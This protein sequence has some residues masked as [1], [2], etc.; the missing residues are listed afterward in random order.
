[1]ATHFH[2][3]MATGRG[4][5]GPHRQGL[6]QSNGV[7]RS[8]RAPNQKHGRGRNQ[9]HP[10]GRKKESWMVPASPPT[11]SIPGDDLEAPS[12]ST[13][14]GAAAGHP[15]GAIWCLQQETGFSPQSTSLAPSLQGSLVLRSF[16]GQRPPGQPPPPRLQGCL[17]WGMAATT[18]ASERARVG[19]VWAAGP[20]SPRSWGGCTSRSGRCLAGS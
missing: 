18:L 10:K 15:D 8:P 3:T 9:K 13:T 17:R 12:P 19:P 16:M 7:Q 2:R 6:P 11:P 1:M 14:V 4:R 5:G 20:R